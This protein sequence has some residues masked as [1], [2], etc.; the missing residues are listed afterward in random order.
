MIYNGNPTPKAIPLREY[1]HLPN[2]RG[3]TIL[4]LGNKG[5]AFGLYRD[6]YL[7][8]GAKSYHCTDLNGLD[9]AILVD[10]RSE[11]A[12]EQIKE[13]TGIE[14]FDIV[15]N[16][17]MSEHIPV[18]RTFYKC[19]HNLTSVGSIMVHWTPRARMFH[20]HGMVGSIFHAEDNFFDKLIIANNYRALSPPYPDGDWGRIITCVLQKQE[21]TE[22]V[23]HSYFRQLFWYNELWETS[24]DAELFKELIQ[25]QDWFTPI[26]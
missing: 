20:E 13:A 7:N 26:P 2:L 4:E 23:W 14:S 17:G 21:D 1:K 3:K 10:L 9:G 24:P 25:S 16:F 19:V 5:N 8:A 22:F 12:A 15:T 6:D 11:T 18:Q